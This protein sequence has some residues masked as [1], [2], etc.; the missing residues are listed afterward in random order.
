MM[1][2][3]EIQIFDCENGHKIE[4]DWED[5]ILKSQLAQYPKCPKCGADFL[6]CRECGN[7]EPKYDQG[8]YCCNGDLITRKQSESGYSQDDEGYKTDILGVENE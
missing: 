3:E 4:L 7:M 6:V 2:E 1:G 8:T 5:V